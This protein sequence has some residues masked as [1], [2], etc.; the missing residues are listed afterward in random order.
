MNTACSSQPGKTNPIPR[1]SYSHKAE[2]HWWRQQRN[3]SHFHPC[4]TSWRQEE[5]PAPLEMS[6]QDLSV[7]SLDMHYP[8]FKQCHELTVLI[9]P[10]AKSKIQCL[11]DWDLAHQRAVL[12]VDFCKCVW[13]PSIIS[14]YMLLTVS[15]C[16][17]NI[18][19]ISKHTQI[20]K[21]IADLKDKNQK[22]FQT[23]A[24]SFHVP[25][26]Y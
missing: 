3:L 14:M 26:V 15:T 2:S 22:H 9:I 18:Q 25:V 11:W 12:K 17:W 13:T 24:H 20:Q 10:R 16:N 8:I 4:S 6:L 23:Q 1:L 19:E 21:I 7:C 5:A